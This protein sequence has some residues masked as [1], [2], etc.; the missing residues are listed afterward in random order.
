MDKTPDSEK[1]K[2]GFFQVVSSVMAAG[3]GVQ[4]SKNRERDFENGSPVVFIVA[5]L[6]FTVIFIATVVTIVS[7]VL[8][9]AG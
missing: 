9:K 2:P 4:S 8:S 6:I 5:G 3:I 1:K 7:T